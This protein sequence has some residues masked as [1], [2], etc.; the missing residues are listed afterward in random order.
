MM[1]LREDAR[2]RRDGIHDR[3]RLA[4]LDDRSKRRFRVEMTYWGKVV[5]TLAGLA[6]GRSANVKVGIV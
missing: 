6:T 3:L 1:A 4:L 2:K 5:G